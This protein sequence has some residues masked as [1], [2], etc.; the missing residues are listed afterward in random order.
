MG[1][2]SDP[3]ASLIDIWIMSRAAVT[4]GIT[5]PKHAGTS[6]RAGGRLNE[7]GG[8]VRVQDG[9]W[10]L[11]V[12]SVRAGLDRLCSGRNLNFKGVQRACTLIQFGRGEKYPRIL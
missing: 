8:K 9:V 6:P 3:I 5:Q 1:E 10:L 2:S 4:K 7:V 12:Q 11:R